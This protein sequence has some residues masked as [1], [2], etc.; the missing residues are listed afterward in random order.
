MPN[1]IAWS[2]LFDET[3]KAMLRKLPGERYFVFRRG[4][5]SV[6]SRPRIFFLGDG[7]TW[8]WPFGETLFESKSQA[9]GTLDYHL[10]IVLVPD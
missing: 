4:R 10:N 7:G 2:V 1:T 6:D 9:Q 8:R 3:D 5:L